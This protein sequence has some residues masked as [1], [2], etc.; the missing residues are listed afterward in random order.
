MGACA[1]VHGVQV[2]HKALHGLIRLAV[3]LGRGTAARMG[4]QVGGL[5]GV[6]PACGGNGFCRRVIKCGGVRLQAHV[7]VA[8]G[9]FARLDGGLHQ[10]RLVIGVQQV[11]QRLA[12]LGAVL[13]AERLANALGHRVVE[14]RHA[15]AAVLVILVGLNGNG[16]QRRIAGNALRL[17]QIAVPGRK[18]AMEQLQQVNLAAG[19]GEGVEVEIMNVNVSLGVRL[20]LCGRKQIGRVIGLG[21]CRANLQHGTHGR[22]AVDVGVI[23]LH[24]AEAGVHIGDLVNRLHQARLCLADARALGAVKDILLGGLFTAGAHQLLLHRVLN[25][26]NL[27]RAVAAQVFQAGLHAVRHLGSHTGVSFAGGLQRFQNSGRNFAL[28]IEHHTPVPLHNAFD[29]NEN[30]SRFHE[31]ARRTNGMPGRPAQRPPGTPHR[32]SPSLAKS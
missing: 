20:G 24:I 15:L 17:A 29:H 14:V 1:R 30:S 3:C 23:A 27:R 26:F 19:G 2:V 31:A 12:Q 7:T 8:R 28:I 4:H 11:F 5:S 22:V 9:L 18:A 32:V 10:R 16:R 6:Q 13:L 21:A 25:L